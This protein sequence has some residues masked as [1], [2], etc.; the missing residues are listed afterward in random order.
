MDG[1]AL[2]VPVR[3]T[4]GPDGGDIEEQ[5]LT[6][7]DSSHAVLL[8]VTAVDDDDA[9][10]ASPTAQSTVP[11]A[12]AKRLSF[13]S[14]AK[15]HLFSRRAFVILALVIVA[16][17]ASVL[18][19]QFT[20][21]DNSTSGPQGDPPTSAPTYISNALLQELEGV[22]DSEALSEPGSPQ[23]RAIG[24]L[25][26]IDE[27]GIE[28]THSRLVQRYVLVVLY[29]AT[30]GDQWPDRDNWLDPS[31]HECQWGST[32]ICETNPSN[33]QIVI[34]LDLSTHGLKGEL[35]PEIGY[36]DQIGMSY[37]FSQAEM[38]KISFLLFFFTAEHFIMS[39]NSLNGTLPASI[40]DMT[41]LGKYA[42]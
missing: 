28:A 3:E 40:F 32:I 27:S 23:R 10:D 18:A 37:R 1:R 21:K 11:V 2:G 7:G 35:P 13:A 42:K 39:S 9:D 16:V 14:W 24:W 38:L 41:R 5:S 20:G 26:S 8:E 15:E 36:L 31:L 22:S 12:Y 33:H 34:G 6:E 17:I 4:S 30:S 19:F 25:S 29:Y